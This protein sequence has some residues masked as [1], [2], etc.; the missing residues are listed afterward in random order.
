EGA[1]PMAAGLFGYLGYDMV[2]LMERLPA[3]KP[4]PLEL[5][6]ALLIRPTLMV[7]FD[8]VRD[9][10]TAVTPGRPPQMVTAR[11]AY[12]RAMERLGGVVDGLDRHTPKLVETIDL[13]AVN[14]QAVSNTSEADY[15]AM[16]E[17]AKA[18]IRAGD[19][20]QVVLSQRFSAPFRLPPFA[21]YRALRRV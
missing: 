15:L 12:L 5:P 1:P 9:E 2:R 11:P 21:L 3:D 7:V 20:F 4:D 14:G 16:V 6:D 13:E 10:I 17:R 18:Y 8:A 19:I